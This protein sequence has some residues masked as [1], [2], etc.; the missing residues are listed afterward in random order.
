MTGA[1][2]VAAGS[3]KASPPGWRKWPVRI[4]VGLAV[5]ALL[6]WSAINLVHADPPLPLWAGQDLPAIPAA[7]DNGWNDLYQHPHLFQ[8]LDVGP[9]ERAV[10]ASLGRAAEAGPAAPE[11]LAEAAGATPTR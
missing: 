2:P 8:E 4:V 10:G 5:G 9:V 11:D 1:E 3:A 6:S 7:E